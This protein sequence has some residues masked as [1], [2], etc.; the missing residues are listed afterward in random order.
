MR[1]II[2]FH[3][4]NYFQKRCVRKR[5]WRYGYRLTEQANRIAT[6]SNKNNY[7]LELQYSKYLPVKTSF[8]IF[9]L[10]TLSISMCTVGINSCC[11][12]RE[13]LFIDVSITNVGLILT[14]PG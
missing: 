6:A 12:T 7:L 14:K 1:I 8:P 4:Y 10:T 9:Q 5:Y 11:N 13:D 3:E 2:S